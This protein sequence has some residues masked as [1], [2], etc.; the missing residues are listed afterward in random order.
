MRPAGA[1]FALVAGLLS[2]GLDTSNARNDRAVS[3]LDSHFLVTWYGNP[4]TARMGILGRFEGDERAEGLRRQ[5]VAYAALTPKHVQPAY[6]LV[7]VVA[8]PTAGQ[9][10][11]WRRREPAGVIQA[12][13]DEARAN[14]FL[15]VLDVQ[16]GRAGVEEE[17]AYL[18]PFLEEPDVH[19]ALDPEFDMGEG[20]VPGRELGHTHAVHVNAALDALEKIVTARDLP[21]KVLIVHQFTM[22]M[23]PD[24][25]QIRPRPRIESRARHGRI[26][27]AVAEA[28]HL[29]N[30][31]AP[32]CA[33]VCRL[34]AVL[35]AGHEPVLAGRRDE[36]DTGAVRSRLSIALE[37][38]A[39]GRG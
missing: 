38:V 16:P 4:H 18:R 23:L 19:L 26:R 34:E 36:V 15:L 12:L 39:G 29:P 13:L 33:P 2:V 3:L 6:H 37:Q 27:L 35:P 25:E 21:P 14:G 31:D 9:D 32:V 10:G 8:Q 30:G 11:K 22:N 28:L 1:V 20:Q 7:A 5:A 24:K 17:V